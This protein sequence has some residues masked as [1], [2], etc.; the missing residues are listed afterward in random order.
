MI[1]FDIGGDNEAHPVYQS[2]AVANG[3]RQYDFLRSIVAASV[4]L[5]RTILSEHILK[6]LNFQAITCLHGNAGEYRPCPVNVGTYQP[7]A[8]YRVPGLMEDFV[9][10]VNRD[11]GTADPVVL[12]AFVLWGLNAIHPFINGNGPP[13]A[14]PAIS[15]CA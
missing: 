13:R 14:P 3:L 9:N 8:H 7:P 5:N 11:F 10:G 2:L 15:C 12:A 6:A 4:Q 1:L